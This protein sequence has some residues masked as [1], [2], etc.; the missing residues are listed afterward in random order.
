MPAEDLLGIQSYVQE[1]VGYLALS[2]RLVAESRFDFK[3]YLRDWDRSY[4]LQVIVVLR[5]LEYIDSAGLAAL[6]GAWKRIK[7]LGGE[8]VVAEL[9]PALKAL[10]EVSSLEKFFRIFSNLEAAQEYFRDSR[11]GIADEPGEETQA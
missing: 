4:P 3:I 10:F 6:I 5:D 11:A 7:E 1:G 8:L 9:N 2:G